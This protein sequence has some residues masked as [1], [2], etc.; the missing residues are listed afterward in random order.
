VLLSPVSFFRF[1]KK[2]YR[3]CMCVICME[4]GSNGAPELFVMLFSVLMP[5]APMDLGITSIFGAAAFNQ[6]MVRLE[7]HS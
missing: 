3:I 1:R 2:L 5:A 7:A 4:F 6:M